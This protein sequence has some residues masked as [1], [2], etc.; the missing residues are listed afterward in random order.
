LR[1]RAEAL[2]AVIPRERLDPAVLAWAARS[3]RARWGLAFS[4]G[5]D[6]LALV[7]LVWALWPGRRRRLVVLH[8]NHRLRGRAAR[9]DAT[10]CR[11]VCA[12]LGLQCV[13]GAWAGHRPGASEAEAREARLGFLRKHARF[14]WFGHQ[15]DDVAET[16]LMRLAR[17]SGAG[18]LAAPRPVQ[19]AGGGRVHLRPL[20]RLRHAELTTALRAAGIAWREDAS[21]ATG[22]YLRNRVRRDILPRWE[23]VAGRDA[24]AGAARSRELL[25]EDDT[26]LEGWLDRVRPLDARGRLDLARLHGAPRA[27]WRRA[28]HRWVLVNPPAAVLSRAAFDTLLQQVESGT[29]TRQ[30]AGRAWFAVS[31]GRRLSLEAAPRARGD[32]PRRGRAN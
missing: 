31:D 9:A 17:G 28:L 15:R 19:S 18:G 27:L 14:L 1:E 3:S 10:F 26:A 7:L 8:F 20:L 24:V 6:S 23:R 21:N 2:A 30:S 29:R 13:T 16:M 5:A 12:R 32:R 25:E 11:Q 4:G 22:L